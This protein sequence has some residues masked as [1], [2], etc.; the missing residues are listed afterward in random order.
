M[1]V[2]DGLVRGASGCECWWLQLFTYWV[3]VLVCPAN[4]V[5]GCVALPVGGVPCRRALWECGG[6]VRLQSPIGPTLSCVWGFSLRWGWCVCGWFVSACWLARVP[7]VFPIFLF[8]GR[9]IVR[10]VR[11]VRFV[12][13]LWVLVV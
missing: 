10:G 11:A 5:R 3:V 12:L 9:A 1:G 7:V 2:P 13:P 6:K 4:F 8:W